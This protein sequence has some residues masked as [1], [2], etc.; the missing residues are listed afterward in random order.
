MFTVFRVLYCSFFP[1]Y[2]PKLMLPKSG[3][4]L[5]AS[6]TY[7][8]EFTLLQISYSPQYHKSTIKSKQQPLLHMTVTFPLQTGLIL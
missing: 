3:C 2:F 1:K 4:G 5:S 8:P 7:T 6:A